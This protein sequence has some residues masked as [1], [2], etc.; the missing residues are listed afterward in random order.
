MVL[1]VDILDVE[2]LTV[3]VMKVNLDIYKSFIRD[4]VVSII[5]LK[6]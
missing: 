3:K 5:L 2:I 6:I 4:I 1:V